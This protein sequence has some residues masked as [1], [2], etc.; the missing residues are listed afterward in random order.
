MRIHKPANCVSVVSLAI[1]FLFLPVSRNVI[2]Q[3]PV[4]L[5][6]TARGIQ[7]YQ[8]GDLDKAIKIL[9]EVVKLSPEDADAWYY[10]ALAF[11]S[12]G[13]IR[14]ALP[15]FERLIELRPDSADGHAKLAYALIIANQPQQAIGMA[16][17]A[18]SLGDQSAETHYAIA[19]ANLRLNSLE[20]AV[21]ESE[22]ALLMKPDFL[23]ALITNSIAHYGLKE[24]SEAAAS[25]EKLVAIG[26]YDMDAETW[27]N[28]LE[29]VRTRAV[30]AAAP[31]KPTQEK[32]T[33]TGKEVTQKARVLDKP[34]PQY[35]EA[36]RLAGVEGT[37]VLRTVFSSSG[38]VKDIY[39]TRALGYGLTTQ[40]IKAARKIKFTPAIKDGRP[41]SMYIQLE[42]NFNLY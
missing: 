21:A 15:R 34:E 20:K 2:A 37:V 16:Q 11:N 29:L 12:Q 18:I 1:V 19:E 13:Q 6:R 9:K 35:T 22:T 4:P 26:S 17:R 7:L 38:E 30:D 14:E 40:T 36:A 5:T 25:L 28:Q 10:L 3:K 8:Q 31:S 24:Y 23:P 33:F 27:R 42:Y 41:V 39:V 32:E